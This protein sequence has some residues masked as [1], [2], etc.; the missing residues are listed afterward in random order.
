MAKAADDN[1]KS[2][3]LDLTITRV[4]KAPRALVWKAW[5]DP[6]H[7]NKWWAPA[8]LLTT[9][10]A[11]DFRPGGGFRSV[12]RAPDGTEYPTNG[13]F[14]DVVTHE[15]MGFHEGWG[16]CLDQLGALAARLKE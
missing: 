16:T 9:E 4:F 11:L 5:T 13:C 12:M 10:C 1:P 8:P 14:L 15:Q 2:Q 6:E 7:L 3:R